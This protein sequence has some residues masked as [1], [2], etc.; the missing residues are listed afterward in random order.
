MSRLHLVLATLLLVSLPAA[1]RSGPSSDTAA[2]P[3]PTVERLDLAGIPRVA[4]RPSGQAFR[5]VR[6]EDPAGRPGWVVT[7]VPAPRRGGAPAVIQGVP[8]P[9]PAVEEGRVLVGGGLGSSALHAFDVRTGRKLWT[10]PLRDNG[11]SAV[12]VKRGRAVVNTE[13]CTTYAVETATGRRVWARTLGPSL[14]ASPTIAGDRVLAAFRTQGGPGFEITA[15]SLGSGETLWQRD[16]PADLVGAPVVAEDR[17][18]LTGQDGR[19]VC[20]DLAD[21]G[22]VWNRRLGASCAPWHDLGGLYV[23]LSS[24]TRRESPAVVRI[25]PRDGRT[26][27]RSDAPPARTGELVTV[28]TPQRASAPLVSQGWCPDPP[29]P[30]ILD[31]RCVIAGGQDLTVLDAGIGRTLRR[32]L[33]PDGQTFHAPPAVLGRRLLYA[34]AQGVLLEID[35]ALGAVRRALDLGVPITSQPVVDHG[36]AYVTAGTLLVA[37]P[38]GEPDDPSW[39]QWGA[40]RNR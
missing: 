26:L 35:P 3:G 21:G 12:A 7:L 1:V 33:L 18:F 32:L 19:L 34:T 17:V 39:P 22:L 20:L 40:D 31:G 6:F 24:R 30:V 4:L 27:W 11:P 38:W 36:R 2:D 16:L 15:L 8:M 10:A 25:D 14:L 28:A 29:R 5:P 13:S 23:A 37:V 9:S